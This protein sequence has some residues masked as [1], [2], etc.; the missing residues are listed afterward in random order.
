MTGD[1]QSRYASGSTRAS[2]AGYP[3]TVSATNN[4]SSEARDSISTQHEV[5]R[6]RAPT[7]PNHATSGGKREGAVGV[8]VTHNKQSS[9]RK[10]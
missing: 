7:G 3:P 8:I 10:E 1:D 5:C 2:A 9:A 4:A 6:V